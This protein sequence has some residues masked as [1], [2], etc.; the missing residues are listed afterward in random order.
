MWP[1][2]ELIQIILLHQIP[3]KNTE[4]VFLVIIKLWFKVHLC[5]IYVF[6]TSCMHN[7][8]GD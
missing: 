2:T 7:L 6:S 8:E 1:S 5:V 3:F 4:I